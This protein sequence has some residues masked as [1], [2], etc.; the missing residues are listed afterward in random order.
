LKALERLDPGR[1]IASVFLLPDCDMACRFCASE[2]GF[3]V[4]PFEEAEALLAGLARR[5]VTNVVLGGGEP[6]LWPH[7]LPRLAL[8]ASEMGH[9]VQ[10]CTNGAALPEGFERLP[11]IDRWVLPLE[12]ADPGLHDRLR[13]REGGGHHA[14]V[15]G[16]I[17]ALARAGRPV[18]ISTVVT[19]EN[20]DALPG[21]AEWLARRRREGVRL[22]AWH[23]YRFLPVGRGGRRHAGALSVSGEAFRA[24]CEAARSRDL[25]FRVYRRDDMLRS[26][27]VEFFWWE[28]ERLALGSE[29][30][31]AT[32]ATPAGGE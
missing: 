22:H 5:G 8:R 6:L 12:S 24:V 28:G 4:M 18:T 26:R 2:R 21:L 3:D 31:G 27:T 20:V 25:G 10:V 30:L 29:A 23:L 17:E 9:L 16:R 7:G 13:P 1:R 19:R 32:S 11:G 14:L 15:V